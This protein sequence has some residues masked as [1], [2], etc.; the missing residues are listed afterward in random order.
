[1]PIRNQDD[2][3]ADGTTDP[4]YRQ[5]LLQLM[6]GQAAQSG[7]TPVST[8]PG[9]TG[10]PQAGPTGTPGMPSPDKQPGVV[11]DPY[12]PPVYDP[13]GT[14]I[15]GTTASKAPGVTTT[16]TLDPSVKPNNPAD[17]AATAAAAPPAASAANGHLPQWL[18]DIYNAA[19][20]TDG[21]AGAGFTDG[22]Y[23]SDKQSQAD[24]LKADLA[25][26]GNDQP[27]PKDAG[28]AL[29][30]GKN[31]PPGWGGVGGATSAPAGSSVLNPL[32]AALGG[33]GSILQQIQA[34]LMNFVQSGNATQAGG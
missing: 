11:I 33:G 27:G 2:P 25:G 32:T 17:P 34:A 12:G 20:V 3:N 19:G 22:A 4:A 18:Q 23:W 9:T 21:G 10:A 30:S 6:G 13:T 14:Q 31:P 16:G 24:R 7:S 28:A 15:G 26:T 1:M 5:Y 29:G 8:S